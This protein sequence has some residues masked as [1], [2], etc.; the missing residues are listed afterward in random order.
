MLALRHPAL[1]P[2]LRRLAALVVAALVLTGALTAGRPYVWCVMMERAM[3][4]CCCALSH[5]DAS[6]PGGPEISASCCEDRALGKLAEARLG[7]SPIELPAATAAEPST[8]PAVVIARAPSFV[9][10]HVAARVRAAPIRAG[11]TA[12]DTCVRLQV[13]RC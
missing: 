3:D 12:T 9:R 10:P 5:D 11:P 6:E 4:A 8:P 2:A 13:F 1:T 7:A